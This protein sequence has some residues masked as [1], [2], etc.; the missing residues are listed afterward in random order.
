MT[1]PRV[2]ASKKDE[3]IQ[4]RVEK[5]FLDQL[6]STAEKQQIPL[7]GMI[8]VW[9]AE[10]LREQ[11][12]IENEKRDKW[13]YERIKL[14]SQNSMFDKGPLLVVH[15]FP[16]G[17]KTRIDVEKLRQSPFNLVPAYDRT[18]IE[19]RIIQ[20]GLEVTRTWKDGKICAQGLAYKTGETE[21]V[22]SIPSEKPKLFIDNLDG[23]IVTAVH[24]LCWMLKRNALAVPYLVYIYVLKAKD[25]AAWESQVQ[26]TTAPPNLFTEDLIELPE[27]MFM[28]LDQ[29]ETETSTGEFLIE[30]IDELWNAAGLPCSQS[31]NTERKWVGKT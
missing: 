10:K 5:N 4:L 17:G 30:Q 20:L 12:S 14:I 24:S 16:L 11:D 6:N 13:R 2:T 25:Y 23:A 28:E 9:L 3:V 29:I 18:N 15:A 22:I 26:F 31:Y 1:P 27:A 19:S 21:T 7:S 8:R